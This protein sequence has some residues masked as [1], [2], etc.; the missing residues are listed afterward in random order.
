MFQAVLD[1][2]EAVRIIF[3]WFP[4]KTRQEQFALQEHVLCRVYGTHEAVGESLAQRCATQVVLRCPMF[5]V[6][7]MVLDC[8]LVVRNC[9]NPMRCSK[10]ESGTAS[11]FES[12]CLFL[13]KQPIIWLKGMICW[14]IL[15]SNICQKWVP[16]MKFIWILKTIVLQTLWM[17]T[18]PVFVEF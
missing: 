5:F 7:E 9:D 18:C 11:K 1:I 10:T 2:L 16:N 17:Q 3:H 13:R 4:S 12:S 6:M 8:E 14:L 15:F